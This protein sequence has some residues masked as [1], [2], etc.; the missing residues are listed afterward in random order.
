MISLKQSLSDFDRLESLQKTAIECYRSA[1]EVA[2]QYVVETDEESTK[3]F[4]EHLDALAKLVKSAGTP[5]DLKRTRASFQIEVQD[6]AGQGTRY[7]RTIKDQLDATTR[8]LKEIVESLNRGGD[9]QERRLR[10]GIAKLGTIARHPQIVRLCPEMEAVVANVEDNVQR[11]QKQNQLVVAQLHDE[12]SS[13]HGA[14][15]NAKQEAAKDP[16]SGVLNRAEMLARIRGGIEQHQEFCLIFLWIS[17]ANYI[18]RTFGSRARDEIITDFCGRLGEVS[19]ADAVL[20]RWADEQFA[21]LVR[22]PKPE[23]MWLADNL[24]NQLAGPYVVKKGS[25]RRE[26]V[27]KL[28]TG[29]VEAEAAA[30]QA[31]VLSL[32]DK[33][34]VA[35]EDVPV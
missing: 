6:Y 32:V 19:G 35:L 18:Y 33:L 14:L 23:A 27:L 10:E 28:K 17:N 15:D 31:R 20:G 16:I 34:L 12:I 4:R 25:S 21:A 1:V 13:L 2:G 9:N 7:L 22:R 3:A 8:A 29:V 5:S 26:V 30:T 11:L 24:A